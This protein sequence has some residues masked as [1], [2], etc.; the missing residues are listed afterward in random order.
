MNSELN[1]WFERH[2]KRLRRKLSFSEWHESFFPALWRE[3]KKEKQKKF[4]SKASSSL[5]KTKLHPERFKARDKRKSLKKLDDRSSE[6]PVSL[7]HTQSRL[8]ENFARRIRTNKSTFY[9]VSFKRVSVFEY[10][11]V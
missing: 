11:P 3:F 10:N 2:S 1:R 8:H 6:F 5:K 9:Y 4:G 7:Y